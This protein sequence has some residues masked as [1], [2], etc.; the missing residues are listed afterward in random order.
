MQKSKGLGAKKPWFGCKNPL[1]W[2]QKLEAL[3]S[4]FDPLSAKTH[5]FWCKFASIRVQISHGFSAKTMGFECKNAG[6]SVQK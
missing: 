5:L 6:V 4:R 1:V 3:D 2:V